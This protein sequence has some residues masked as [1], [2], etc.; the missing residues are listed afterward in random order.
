MSSTVVPSNANKGAQLSNVM[1]V[2]ET[3]RFLRVSESMVRRLIREKKVSF[4]NIGGRYLFSLPTLEEWIRSQ[5]IPATSGRDQDV[6]KQRATRMW[7]RKGEKQNG[8]TA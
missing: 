6:P 5:I 4:F 2:K 8:N 7:D 3:A 1:N